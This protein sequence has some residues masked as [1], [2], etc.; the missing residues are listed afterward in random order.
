MA[1]TQGGIDEG[2]EE[3]LDVCSDSLEKSR[4]DGIKGAGGGSIG[5]DEGQD[6]F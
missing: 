6:I 1:F 4:R 3:G 5:P 2:S